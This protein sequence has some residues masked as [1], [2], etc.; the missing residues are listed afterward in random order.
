MSNVDIPVIDATASDTPLYRRAME[1]LEKS[2]LSPALLQ[3]EW[4]CPQPWLIICGGGHVAWDLAKMAAGLDLRIKVMDD[5]PEFANRERFP[6]V[7]EVV[8]DSFANF[9]RYLEP[10]AF[11]VVV[12]RGHQD[13]LACVRAVLG[14]DYRYLGMMGSRNKVAN[15]FTAL[16]TE[17]FSK[18]QLQ[19]IFAPIGL[20]ISAVTPAEIAVSILAE[21]IRE[22]NKTHAAS[23]TRELLSVE[24][25]GVLCIITEKRGS[26]PRGA[27]SMMFVGKSG[28]ILGSIGGGPVE[29][30]AIA[31]A[32]TL[33]TPK[34]QTYHL[35]MQDSANLGM[36]CG[37]SIQVLF[38]P[39]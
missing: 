18:E 9:G 6:F 28:N 11:Y 30:E 17:G 10:N 2:D 20:P 16:E 27:G 25:L 15:A 23:A 24:E 14:S 36:V 1:A 5:R 39:V 3:K 33:S 21:I 7:D 31:D 26:S 13:D 35:H 32:G 12:T 22:K 37:G 4:F 8:C 29:S 38:I 34:L 19:S